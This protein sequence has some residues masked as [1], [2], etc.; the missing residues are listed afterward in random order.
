MLRKRGKKI[1]LPY[2][3]CQFVSECLKRVKGKLVAFLTPQSIHGI[4]SSLIF[5]QTVLLGRASYFQPNFFT[6]ILLCIV[7]LSQF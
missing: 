6:Q 4:K 1:H 5:K 2:T 7:P 3:F